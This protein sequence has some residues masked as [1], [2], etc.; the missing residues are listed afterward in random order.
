MNIKNNIIDTEK[1]IVNGA[2][3]V[4]GKMAHKKKD[5]LSDEEISS[6]C[7]SS[8]FADMFVNVVENIGLD[9]LMYTGLIDEDL[10]DRLCGKDRKRQY[11]C[12]IYASKTSAVSAFESYL[13]GDQSSDKSIPEDNIERFGMYGFWHYFVECKTGRLN[14]LREGAMML[15]GEKVADVIRENQP[16]TCNVA[17]MLKNLNW[18][19]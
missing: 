9:L 12:S 10:L 3:G 5:I 17:L 18:K 11:V 14:S 19:K 1:K 16:D 4:I 15:S 2:K 13:R 8:R 7:V 6:I